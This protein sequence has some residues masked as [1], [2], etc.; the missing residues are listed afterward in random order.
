MGRGVMKNKRLSICALLFLILPAM[1]GCSSWE[2]SKLVDSQR[3]ETLP[4]WAAVEITVD[5][6]SPQLNQLD[7]DMILD[8]FGQVKGF[9][10]LPGAED[11]LLVLAW[12]N[13]IASFYALDIDRA[14]VDKLG[15]IA[16]LGA[17]PAV[18]V[19][20]WP[21]VLL[22]AQDEAGNHSWVLLEF[23]E[24]QVKI[25]WQ[26]SAWVPW[27]IRRQ[28]IWFNGERWFMGPVRGPY[29]TDILTGKTLCKFEG[30]HNPVLHP[31][32]SWAG[33][34]AAAPF[35]LVPKEEG[36]LLVDLASNTMSPLYYDQGL[37]WNR[38]YSMLA[39]QQ[40][41]SLGFVDS[42][43]KPR[44][45]ASEGI[46]PQQPLWSADGEDLFFFKGSND[47]FGACCKELWTWNEQTGSRRLFTLPENWPRWQLLAAVSNAVL[48][49]A[50]E[51]GDLLVYF[52]L[53]AGKMY[54]LK[55]SAYAWQ[56]GDLVALDASVAVRYSPGKNPRIIFRDVSDLK[57]L[58]LLNRYFIYS[59]DGAVH[60][61]ELVQ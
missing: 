37:A 51:N 11:S 55:E 38:D 32:P 23:L 17:P 34:T 1:G 60:I 15:A 33:G 41:G 46:V 31:W 12:Q 2:Q 57:I 61:K 10:A 22:G 47:L 48:A 13:G 7:E 3:P 14:Q 27:G 6:A 36:S 19:M 25:L 50:G 59:L 56:A 16:L 53:A 8:G 18:E 43:G 52:D 58:A 45:L 24:G 40:D 42:A 39:W 49:Q 21:Q 35:Y 30:G 20:A 9:W 26:A 44:N 5:P 28:P 4:V 54:E 29:F